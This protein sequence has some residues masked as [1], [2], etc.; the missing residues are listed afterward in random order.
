MDR[1]VK[2]MALALLVALFPV[3]TFGVVM[4]LLGHPYFLLL[5]LLLL[6][7]RPL[8]RVSARATR[9]E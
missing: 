7:I 6:L 1:W 3:A 8:R 5:L 9:P 2:W 4:A